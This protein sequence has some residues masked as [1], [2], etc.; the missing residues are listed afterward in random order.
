M[1]DAA[2]SSFTSAELVLLRYI[3]SHAQTV[4]DMSARELAAKAGCSAATVVRLSRK[5]GYSGYTEYRFALRRQKH[6]AVSAGA[7]PRRDILAE[8]AATSH[9]NQAKDIERT[10]D[11]LAERDTVIL[12]GGG[13]TH[14]ALEY[15]HHYLFSASCPTICMPNDEL[16]LDAIASAGPDAVV[17]CAS[18]S[19]TGST[20]ALA[21]EAHNRG[22]FVIGITSSLTSDLVTFCD[23]CLLAT[24]APRTDSRIASRLGIVAIADEIARTYSHRHHTGQV[25]E[26]EAR[27]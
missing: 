23:I 17:L 22:L 4:P 14:T 13:L 24:S 2:T 7:L 19:G 10:A 25:I 12:V 3:Q 21:R 16:S 8:T 11:L 26:K 27:A 5:L 20:L 18:V 6:P 15:L 9:L 1:P